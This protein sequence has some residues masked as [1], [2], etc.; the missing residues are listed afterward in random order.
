MLSKNAFLS[1]FGSGAA[2]RW[3]GFEALSANATSDLPR[4]PLKQSTWT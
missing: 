2:F 3:L 1:C 4:E